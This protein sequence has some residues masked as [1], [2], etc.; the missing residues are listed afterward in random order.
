MVDVSLIHDKIGW[1]V[2]TPVK[3]LY[4]LSFLISMKMFNN[5]NTIRRVFEY[6][7]WCRTCFEKLY[8]R[9][10]NRQIYSIS[11]THLRSYQ[12]PYHLCLYILKIVFKFIGLSEMGFRK[13]IKIV[14]QLMYSKSRSLNLLDNH[15][16]EI[17]QW[18]I[19]WKFS[20]LKQ[21]SY[22]WM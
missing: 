15:H 4:Q 16:F 7:T 5:F 6:F 3:K 19:N 2:W 8:H 18:R 22:H 9:T 10:Q 21:N 11:R 14:Y 13:I 1:E 12:L 17:L 20:L